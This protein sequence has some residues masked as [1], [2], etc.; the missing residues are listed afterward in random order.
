MRSLRIATK[1]SPWS[2]QLEKVRMQQRRPNTAKYERNKQIN[3]YIYLKK[4]EREREILEQRH[5][6]NREDGHV[7]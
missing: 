1:S 7:R 4:K 3:K 2:P 6:Y 5:T